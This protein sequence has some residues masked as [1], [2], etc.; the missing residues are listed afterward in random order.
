M[1]LVWVIRIGVI[2]SLFT[3]ASGVFLSC[4]GESSLGAEIMAPMLQDSSALSDNLIIPGEILDGK[5]K[6]PDTKHW[7]PGNTSLSNLTPAQKSKVRALKHNPINKEIQSAT[8][9]IQVPDTLPE[10][11]DWRDNKGDWTT[12]VK[13]QG[14]E[15]GSCWAHAAIGILE[16]YWKITHKDPSLVLDLS[17]QYLISCDMDDSGCDGGDF[18]TAMPYLVDKPGPEGGIGTVKEGE[19][20][21]IE[22]M[23]ECRN[24]SGYTRYK[25]DKWA[26]VN[27]TAEQDPELSIPSVDELKAAIY[28]KGPIAV[29]VQDDDD[30]D[31][32]TGGIFSSDAEYQDTNHAVILVGWG[33]EDGEEYFIGKNSAGTEW[34]EDGW[35][36]IDVHSNRI[37]EGAVYLDTIDQK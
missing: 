23:K 15:C 6:S 8:P 29:G 11:F 5:Q 17:E 20:P 16:S 21:Y 31:D 37:G 3:L 9:P 33:D 28:L 22:N 10:S 1:N 2:M 34:G 12:P 26:Y 35:F 25:A 36:K 4:S 24:L 13:D 30:F 14:E 27:A 19:Y 18:D 32:Y 7:N